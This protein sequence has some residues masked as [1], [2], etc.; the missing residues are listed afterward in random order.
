MRCRRGGWRMFLVLVTLGAC[1]QPVW[2]ADRS[3]AQIVRIYPGSGIR[4][5]TPWV[6]INVPPV[7]P[8][9]LPR[10][11]PRRVPPTTPSVTTPA[12]LSPRQIARMDEGRLAEALERAAVSL[13]GELGRYATA[14]SWRRYLALPASTL[15][16]GSS[17][18]VER[19][20]TLLTR[21]DEVA[22]N[23]EYSMISGLRSFGS[24]HQ[25]LQAFVGRGRQSSPTR[26]VP[27][28]STVEELPLPEDSRPL[29]PAATG[30]ATA[31]AA[32]TP[33]NETGSPRRDENVVPAG[34][35][36]SILKQH[37]DRG[38]P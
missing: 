24:T 31:P 25:L 37:R 20:A 9:H 30:S 11:R 26:S 28:P 21:Y 19:L 6:D 4:V 7:L 8:R 17:D 36:R 2:L 3:E 22:A 15:T 10:Y 32:A 38:G 18:A 29:S 23:S 33:A 13:Y 34:V 14:E 1:G 12:N 27:N 16:P 5:R 35:E